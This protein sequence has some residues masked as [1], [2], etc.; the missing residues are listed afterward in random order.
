MKFVVNVG[1]FYKLQRSIT[2]NVNN[3]VTKIKFH[4]LK[5][6]YKNSTLLNKIQIYSTPPYS[7]PVSTIFYMNLYK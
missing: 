6:F 2:A 1:C 3:S 5:D 7:L 4:V